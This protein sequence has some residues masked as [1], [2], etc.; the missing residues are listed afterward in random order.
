MVD[1]IHVDDEDLLR[2]F[3]CRAGGVLVAEVE[4]KPQF[5]KAGAAVKTV[6]PNLQSR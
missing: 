1:T 2:G 4:A 5:L 6:L 3:G